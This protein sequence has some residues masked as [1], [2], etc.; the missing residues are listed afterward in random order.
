MNHWTQSEV[1]FLKENWGKIDTYLIA[2]KLRRKQYAVEQ[3]YRKVM[4]DKK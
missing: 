1:D 2:W 4:K 3:K